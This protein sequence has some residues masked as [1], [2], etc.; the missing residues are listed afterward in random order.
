M[1][2]TLNEITIPAIIIGAFLLL[3]EA[4]SIIP[5]IPDITIDP[6]VGYSGEEVDEMLLERTED[7]QAYEASR[8]EDMQRLEAERAVTATA[9][10]NYGT[11][12]GN[13][14]GW[15]G[16]WHGSADPNK[17]YMIHATP[18]ASNAMKFFHGQYCRDAR[19][20]GLIV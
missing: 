9:T 12:M 11:V 10:G 18:Y 7:L 1:A 5:I 6:L 8:I 2:I 17:C 4:K 13:E 16:A 19:E 15:T 20:Q 3:R 14:G